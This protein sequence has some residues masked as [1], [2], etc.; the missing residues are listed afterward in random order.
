MKREEGELRVAYGAVFDEYAARVPLFVPR[1]SGGKGA[2]GNFSW[3]QYIHNREYQAGLGVLA[4][5]GA[6]FAIVLLR[7]R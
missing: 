1:F 5:I 4:G 2:S 7:G 6:L 3:K